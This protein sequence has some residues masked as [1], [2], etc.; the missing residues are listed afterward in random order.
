MFKIPFQLICL[1]S[2]FSFAHANTAIVLVDMQPEFIPEDS[3]KA[4]VLLEKQRE[5]LSWGLLNN[6]AL[7]VFEFDQGGET[8]EPL[9]KLIDQFDK[10]AIVTKYQN[11]G[12]YFHHHNRVDPSML[13]RSWSIDNL[14]ITG[15]PPT[16]SITSTTSLE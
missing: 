6:L 13:L 7:I 1:L 4:K 14:I 9:K 12:F 8:L 5:L 11:G 10:K 2:F 3:R 16:C 15:V